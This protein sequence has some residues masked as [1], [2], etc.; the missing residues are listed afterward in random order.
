MSKLKKSVHYY[1]T[2]RYQI[3][4]YILLVK[5]YFQDNWWTL[6]N[7]SIYDEFGDKWLVNDNGPTGEM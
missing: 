4:V 1:G 5:I 2:F 3:I 7:N 6:I